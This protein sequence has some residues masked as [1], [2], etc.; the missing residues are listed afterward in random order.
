VTMKKVYSLNPRIEIKMEEIWW[1]W[2]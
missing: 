2:K 1:N